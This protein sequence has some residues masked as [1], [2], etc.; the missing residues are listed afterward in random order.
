MLNEVTKWFRHSDPDLPKSQK[1]EPEG[2]DILGLEDALDDCSEGN[3][4]G[5]KHHADSNVLLVH[6][7]FGCGKSYLLVAIIRFICT[8]LD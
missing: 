5:V 6:G 2:C 4:V 3:S 7:A 8:L 1:E